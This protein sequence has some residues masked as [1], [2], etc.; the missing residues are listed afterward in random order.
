MCRPILAIYRKSKISI[1]FNK[2]NHIVLL[3]PL[4]KEI[5]DPHQ[6]LNPTKILLVFI[7]SYFNRF[8]FTTLLCDLPIIGQGTIIPQF[9]LQSDVTCECQDNHE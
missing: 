5:L 7:A 6:D 9:N 3:A 1:S 8:I 2:Y 4:C